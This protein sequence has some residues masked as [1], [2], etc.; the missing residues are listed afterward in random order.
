QP[1]RCIGAQQKSLSS[2]A[3]REQVVGS[4]SFGRRPAP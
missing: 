4:S 3:V 2:M 1:S